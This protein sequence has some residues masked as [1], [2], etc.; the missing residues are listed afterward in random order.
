MDGGDVR[1]VEPS[2]GLRFALEANDV[3]GTG[4]GIA[5]HLEGDDAI[6]RNLPGPVDNAHSAGAEA[7]FNSEIADLNVSLETLV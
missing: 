6:E 1:V 7:P 2:G 4:Q 3:A 5:K